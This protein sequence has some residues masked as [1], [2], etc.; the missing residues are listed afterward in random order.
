MAVLPQRR[1]RNASRCS[2]R[3]FRS[4]RTFLVFLFLSHVYAF[5][6]D[7]HDAA[8]HQH[9]TRAQEDLR[10]GRRSRSCDGNPVSSLSLAKKNSK[11]RGGEG[12]R[13]VEASR[14]KILSFYSA[15]PPAPPPSAP[16]N[17][18]KG[19]ERQRGAET[20]MPPVPDLLPTLV[21]TDKAN[22]A[23][24][25]SL[26]DQLGLAAIRVEPVELQEDH[27]SPRRLW[28][29]NNEECRTTWARN[30]SICMGLKQVG[31]AEAHLSAWKRIAKQN[32]SMLVLEKDWTIGTHNV[33][34]VRSGLR[35]AYGRPEDYVL[36]GSCW[37]FLCMHAYIMKP[38]LAERLSTLPNMCSLVGPT[39]A[40]DCP[41]DWLPHY[42]Q[43]QGHLSIYS[44]RGE[45]MPGCFGE[46]L[47]QQARWGDQAASAL[48]SPNTMA[49]GAAG[50]RKPLA[51]EA[52]AQEGVDAIQAEAAERLQAVESSA[53]ARAAIM[54]GWDWRRGPWTDAM[55][56]KRAL[57][58][59]QTSSLVSLDRKWQRAGGG[60]I[61]Q[62]LP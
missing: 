17:M 56:T 35:E 54:L 31:I 30:D 24:K 19:A 26:F 40:L 15:R 60:L 21:I 47:I 8:A 27:C 42:L 11:R 10:R 55:R 44:V 49:P 57:G 41:V 5:V 61:P 58:R 34:D 36:A 14:N 50:A 1:S 2:S 62:L 23:A 22:F 51:L 29:I 18:P 43:S 6:Q 20:Q 25:S 3:L 33:S 12:W 13:Y 32:T 37:Y 9:S 59:E 52:S 28:D 48:D 7:V 38:V 39:P 16:Y 46:G 53:C 45:Q 4:F